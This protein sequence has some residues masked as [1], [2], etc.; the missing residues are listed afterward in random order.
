MIGERFWE[1]AR[2]RAYARPLVSDFVEFVDIFCRALLRVHRAILGVNKVLLCVHRIRLRAYAR[3][4]R[5]VSL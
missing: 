2:I 3:P 5:D 1:R 4:R